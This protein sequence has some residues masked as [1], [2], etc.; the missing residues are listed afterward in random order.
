MGEQAFD[1]L[2]APVA[3]VCVEDVPMPYSPPLEARVLP[4]AD[5]IARAVRTL[6]GQEGS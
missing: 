4:D 1:L 2:D 3:R 6:L 5:R